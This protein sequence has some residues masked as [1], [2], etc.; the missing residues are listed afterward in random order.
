MTSVKK[1]EQGLFPRG[2]AALAA[3]PHWQRPNADLGHKAV[4]D[5]IDKLLT[6]SFMLDRKEKLI[7]CGV[8]CPY[9]FVREAILRACRRGLVAA[10]AAKALESIRD[11]ANHAAERIRNLHDKR[12]ALDEETKAELAWDCRPVPADP[13]FG[14]RNR[15][16][17]R[18]LTEACRPKPEH[19]D[20]L[21][22]NSME[23]DELLRQIETKRQDW[24]VYTV[25]SFKSVVASD[26]KDVAVITSLYPDWELLTGKTPASTRPSD[27]GISTNFFGFYDLAFSF[28][29]QTKTWNKW[30]EGRVKQARDLN[31]SPQFF[32]QHLLNP[33]VVLIDHPDGVTEVI[34]KEESEITTRDLFDQRRSLGASIRQWVDAVRNPAVDSET[35]KVSEFLLTMARQHS[36]GAA[37]YIASLGVNLPE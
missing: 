2:R 25:E 8:F 26:M 34:Q 36:R 9:F 27:Q 10:G 35:K 6:R 20:S 12:K 32:R 14:Y 7:E 17:E 19:L 4:D 5:F 3:R 18:A 33:R 15:L 13:I 23:D 1:I 31:S 28:L 21:S 29:G 16:K 37:E 30:F 11:E 24:A 22:K